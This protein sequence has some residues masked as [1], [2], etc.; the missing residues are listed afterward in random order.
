MASINVKNLS[1]AY[2]GAFENIFEQVS[3]SLDTSWKLGLIGRNGRGKTTLLRLLQNELEYTGII[4]HDTEF[5]YFPYKINDESRDVIDIIGDDWRIYKEL[6]LLKI[7]EDI[8]FRPYSSLSE[9]EKT[10][11]LLASMFIKE[12]SFL[13]IDEP[14]NH[15]DSEGRALL[16][17]Y[18]RRKSGFILVSH[19]RYFLDNCVDHIMAINRSDIEIVSGN[20]SSWSENK[21]NRDNFER[22]QNTKLKKE[23][24]R[25]GETA[26]EKAVWS[27]AVE[28]TKY[29]TKNSGLRPD[30]G[31]IGHQAAKMM[32]RSK[33]IEK[34]IEGRIEEKESLLKNIESADN[35]KISPLDFHSKRL[36]QAKDITIFYDE[37]EVLSGLSF[38]I[39]QGE[40]INLSGRNGSGKSSI[41]KLIMGEDIKYSGDFFKAN[42]LSISYISQNTSHLKGRLADFEERAQLDVSLFRA[43][44]RKLD[45]SRASFDKPIETYSAGQK[46]KLLIAKSLSQRAH[47]YIWDEPLN[48]IDVLS[49][50]Q[51]ENLVKASDMSLVFVE[52]DRMFCDN[53][54]DTIIELDS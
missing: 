14:T 25:L 18:L 7:S 13:L 4:S 29:G 45:F 26:A 37:H 38:E 43:I 52:H 5:S 22:E 28:K 6:S 46:K 49:R 31:Y 27:D 48:Y 19:D 50:M 20:F 35:L 10:K 24:K 15:L 36:I 8:L 40:K 12:N 2:D 30:R 47:I 33:S 41:L 32:K 9:G 54:A 1:F 34:R 44:L 42:G 16:S 11:V 39:M 23:I 3:F 51:I 17:A 21:D 53:I